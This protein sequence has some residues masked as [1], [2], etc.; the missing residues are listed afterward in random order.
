MS[1][2]A[3]VLG[4]LLLA[5]A[6]AVVAHLG[7]PRIR[8]RVRTPEGKPTVAVLPFRN[9]SG[10]P[11]LEIVSSDVTAAVGEA[12]AETGRASVVPRETT[13]GFELHRR[14]IEEAAR[15]LGADYLIAGSLDEEDGR[16]EVDAYLFRSGATPALWVER[17]QFEASERSSIAPDLA[18]RIRSIL[19]ER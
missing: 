11:E 7:R 3:V 12:V 4:L 14:G 2:R 19:S 16:I 6:L 5:T 17:L 9:L 18:A 15:S 10:E 13:L 8:L 1:G